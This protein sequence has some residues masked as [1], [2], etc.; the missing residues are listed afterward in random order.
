[1]YICTYYL[2]EFIVVMGVRLSE[3]GKEGARGDW[4]EDGREDGREDRRTDGGRG[5][6]NGEGSKKGDNS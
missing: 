1:M 5:S 6:G 4:M 2:V 3:K